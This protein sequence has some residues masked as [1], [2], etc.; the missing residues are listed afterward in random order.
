VDEVPAQQ[1]SNTFAI[2][3]NG[4]PLPDDVDL[5]SVSVEDHLHLPDAFM[6]T[7][8]D[9]PRSA[10]VKCGAKIGVPVRI[11]VLS[12]AAAAK[13]TLISGEI[14]AVEAE[15]HAAT[16]YTI[17]RGYD[18]SHRLFRGRATD[19]YRNMTYADVAKKIARRNSLKLGTIDATS[20]TYRH[21]AQVNETDWD[22]LGGLAGEV[23]F[24]LA[25]SDGKLHF[26]TPVSSK[27]AP[28]Q[29]DLQSDDPLTLAVGANLLSLRSAVT[30]AQ[31]VKEVQVR[32]WDP[33]TKQAVVATA[34]A[35]TDSIANGSSPAQMA[36]AFPGPP[37]VAA[38]TPYAQAK[39]VETAAKALAAHVA[40]GYTE[41]EGEA[42]GN[43]RLRSG[44]AVRIDLLG[45]PFDGT[46][47][48]TSTRH[49]YDADEGYVTGFTISG[50]EERSLFDLASGGQPDAAGIGGVVP[51]LIDDVN[52]P[53]HKCRVRLRFPW[54]ADSFVSDWSRVVQPGAGKD[55]GLLVMPEVGDEV[56]AAFEQGDIRRAFVLGG[57]YNDKDTAQVGPGQLL[58]GST[59][60]INNRLFTSRKGHHLL[61]VDADQD[62]GVVIATGDGKI[63]IRLDQAHQKVSLT[64]SGDLDIQVG[65]DATIAAKGTLA[66]KANEVKVEAQLDLGATAKQLNLEGSAVVQVKGQMI[67]LN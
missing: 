23:G 32:G 43:P 33:V 9:G 40:G 38:A 51:A 7:L 44:A 57:L 59:N 31:Q 25:V 67:K 35:A 19:S 14:T 21:I 30:A 1:I 42:R 41:M 5:A 16:S 11:S 45:E 63:Q 62:C 61:F 15:I 8:R 2:E 26:R 64:S 39:E 56:L 29:S 27:A 54:L 49:S 3:V 10:L 6:F 24:E 12:D 18:Q 60:A 46:Y 65:G 34:P 17:V 28:P 58:D 47:V 20:S 37:L 48:L 50:R 66:L 55:R 52:D 53:D 13:Q 4:R 22:F 36:Q